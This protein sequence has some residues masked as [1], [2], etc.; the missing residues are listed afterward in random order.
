M[1]KEPLD[2]AIERATAVRWIAEFQIPGFEIS[3]SILTAYERAQLLVEDQGRE[4]ESIFADV[5]RS[6]AIEE[7]RAAVE[8]LCSDVHSHL[9]KRIGE[10][11][12][13]ISELM[14][15]IDGCDGGLRSRLVDLISQVDEFSRFLPP[16]PR[17]FVLKS[18]VEK[19]GVL[20][21]E[22]AFVN[23]QIGNRAAQ[24]SEATVAV[25]H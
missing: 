21:W 11:R 23:R 16:T 1:G 13:R 19:Y 22:V 6:L 3:P 20:Y 25:S 4:K 18:T 5:A 7:Y 12:Q 24:R 9:H 2:V 17:D 8:Q 15:G 14:R 10:I